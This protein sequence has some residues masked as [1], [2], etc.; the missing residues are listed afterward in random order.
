MKPLKETFWNFVHKHSPKSADG[1]E[2]AQLQAIY[3]MYS[4]EVQ[5]E[6][7][8]TEKKLNE[9]RN[10]STKVRQ[11]YYRTLFYMKRNDK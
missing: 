10:E 7:K 5:D 2:F 6:I 1:N 9:L 3:S 11:A 4:K 8:E